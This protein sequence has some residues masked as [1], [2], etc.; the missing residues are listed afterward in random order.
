MKKA[1]KM[2]SGFVSKGKSMFNNKQQKE[3]SQ[4]AAEIDNGFSSGEDDDL[5][6][7]G[8]HKGTARGAKSVFE[9]LESLTSDK[10]IQEDQYANEFKIIESGKAN[11]LKSDINHIKE[12]IEASLDK[13]MDLEESKELGSTISLSEKTCYFNLNTFD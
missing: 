11:G 4:A 9:D 8:K 2:L 5:I 12:A 3:S 6:E 13:P 7:I 10:I 1:S